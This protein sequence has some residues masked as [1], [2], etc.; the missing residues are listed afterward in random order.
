VSVPATWWRS[1]APRKATGWRGV[2]AQHII[3]TLR[4]VDSAAEQQALEQWLEASKPP[5]PLDVAPKQHYL[6]TTP[7]RYRS[8]VASRFRSAQDGGLWYGAEDRETVCAELAYW[9]WRFLMDTEAPLGGEVLTSHT[10]F[11][12]NV[13]GAS[14]DLSEAPWSRTRARWMA[15]DYAA[16]QALAHECRERDVAWIRYESARREGGFC[17]AVIT[18][19]ALTFRGGSDETWQCKTTPG[20]VLM[21]HEEESLAFDAAAWAAEHD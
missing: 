7:F 1:I 10:L 20:R 5:L 16:C 4:L 2:E 14:I 6:L 3:A 19:S 9:R 11:A 12:A 13:A 8:P 18:P 15:P 21:V 17:S